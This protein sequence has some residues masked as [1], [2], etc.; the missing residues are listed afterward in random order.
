[1]LERRLGTPWLGSGDACLPSGSP[2]LTG[3][4]L[5]KRDAAI[6]HYTGR[7]ASECPVKAVLCDACSVSLSVS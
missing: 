1:M 5:F 3:Q 6:Q 7:P 4:G 2:G